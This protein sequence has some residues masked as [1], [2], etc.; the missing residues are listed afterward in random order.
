M[1]VMSA[2]V[3]YTII[4][5][6]VGSC[7]L[8]Q[9]RESVQFASEKYG[10]SST[11]VSE[12]CYYAATCNACPQF[13]RIVLCEKF[14]NDLSRFSLISGKARTGMYPMPE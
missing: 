12:T 14:R 3:G 8:L 7:T 13:V 4:Y 6:T 2:T 9:D 11:F 10:R 1:S 5:G